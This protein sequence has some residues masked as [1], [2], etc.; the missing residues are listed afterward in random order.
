KDVVE[1]RDE[2][3]HEH[4]LLRDGY[5][6]RCLHDLLEVALT[7][8]ETLAFERVNDRVAFEQNEIQHARKVRIGFDQAKNETD[9]ST[10]ES[11]DVINDDYERPVALTKKLGQFQLQSGGSRLV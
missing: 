2:H 1:S 9:L 10:R 7:R 6:E 3:V 8:R 4:R 5:D 11:I